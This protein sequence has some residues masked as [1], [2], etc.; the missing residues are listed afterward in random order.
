MAPTA[1]VH[2]A[3]AGGIPPDA[4]FVHIHGTEAMADVTIEP[5]RPGRAEARIHIANEDFS[6]FDAKSV[7]LTLDPPKGGGKPVSRDA[8]FTPD[9][10]WRI[11]GIDISGPGIWTATV[12]VAPQHGAPIS[13]DAPVVIDQ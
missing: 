8:V 4:A 1:H 5:G 7:R 9:G 12:I 13:L 10:V 3:P 6:E 2:P 11:G